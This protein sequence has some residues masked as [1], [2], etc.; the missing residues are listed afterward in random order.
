MSAERDSPI[1][2]LFSAEAIRQRVAALAGEIGAVAAPDLLAVA[3]LKGSFVFAADLLRALH[4]A[5]VSPEVD[6]LMLES[7]GAERAS[8]GD[9][10]LVRDIESRVMGRD[11]LLIDDI[12]ESGRTLSYARKL[13]A[14]RG[15]ASVLTCVLLDKQS[16][17]HA[18]I[19]ADFRGF[20]C[21]ADAFAVGY[22]MDL[23]HRY[24]ELPFIGRAA[25]SP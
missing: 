15:A 10:R 3:I 17:R 9:V 7:Y 12:L 6:F 2:P 13:I 16:T 23:A 21:P 24:R 18:P 20:F 1:E 22:G 25:P 14:D 8:S 5:G 11:V 4:G 19:E